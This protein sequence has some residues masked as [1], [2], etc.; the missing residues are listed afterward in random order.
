MFVS[1]LCHKIC[2]NKFICTTDKTKN[3]HKF[4]QNKL[5]KKRKNIIDSY[6]NKQ[7]SK[8]HKTL[9]KTCEYLKRRIEKKKLNV[10]CGKNEMK[11]NKILVGQY[12]N[13]V[14]KK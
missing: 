13:Y 9:K 5:R 11:K 7:Q 4:Q 1:S 3:W 8:K 10:I 12:S 14:R 2:D 6:K